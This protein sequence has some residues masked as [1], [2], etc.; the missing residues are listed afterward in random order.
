MSE[1]QT[2]GGNQECFEKIENLKTW[3]F[4]NQLKSV[5][6]LLT[7]HQVAEEGKSVQKDPKELYNVLPN[8]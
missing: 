1:C 2:K 3:N 7:L 5:C 8:K 4:E 6:F